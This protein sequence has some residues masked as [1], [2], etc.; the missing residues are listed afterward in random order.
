[1]GCSNI[2]EGESRYLASAGE[3]SAPGLSGSPVFDESGSLVGLMRGFGEVA[4][5]PSEFGVREFNLIST[6]DRA[7]VYMQSGLSAS[8]DTG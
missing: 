4:E 1:L 5:A 6:M 3:L 2:E 7:L 8:L